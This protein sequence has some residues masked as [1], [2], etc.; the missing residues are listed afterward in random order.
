MPTAIQAALLGV[1]QGLTEFLP[2]SSS[3]HLI[4]ARAFFG[5]DV[6]KFGLSFDVACHIGTFVAVL[7]YFRREVTQMIVSV[8]RIFQ[9]GL[10]QA[11]HHEV[12]TSSPEAGR[13]GLAAGSGTWAAYGAGGPYSLGNRYGVRGDQG[14]RLLW[15][16]VIGTVPAVIVGLLFSKKIE[17]HL[18]TPPVA[19]LALAL[20]AVGLF[21][22]ERTSHKTRSD[23][24]L[25]MAEAFWLGCAQAVALIPGV[26]R[27]GVTMTVALLFGLR[28]PAAARFV[29][30]LAIPAIFAAA[31]HEG[32]EV[33]K[34][35]PGADVAMLFIIGVVSSA[36]VGYIAVTWF[37]RYLAT[38][39]LDVFAWYRLALSGS[40]VIWLW[41]A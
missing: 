21:I 26:S 5:F 3:A 33:F 10:A 19:A 35:G 40:V 37:I 22:A 15:L 4:L 13:D 23:G 39:S 41:R 30:L 32:V 11:G 34:A 24:S 27:S 29:F 8:P 18:R 25:T 6:D 2:V 20:G 14:V 17:E 9:P 31:A 36:I 28:R 16:L 38:H 1:V 7:I 12:A